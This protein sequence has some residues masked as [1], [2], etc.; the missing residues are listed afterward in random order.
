[1]LTREQND[2]SNKAARKGC[3]EDWA[4]TIQAVLSSK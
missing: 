4:S 1:M 3:Q 2:H